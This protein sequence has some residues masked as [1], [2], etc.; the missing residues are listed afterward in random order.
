MRVTAYSMLIFGVLC[1]R[2]VAAAPFPRMDVNPGD[3]RVQATFSNAHA[4]TADT[5]S[6][7]GENVH[8]SIHIRGDP[9]TND[10]A[11]AEDKINANLLSSQTTSGGSSGTTTNDELCEDKKTTECTSSGNGRIPGWKVVAKAM[12]GLSISGDACFYSP[13]FMLPVVL[14]NHARFHKMMLSEFGLLFQVIAYHPANR[15]PGTDFART[16]GTSGEESKN[17]ARES[18]CLLDPSLWGIVGSG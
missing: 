6:G 2:F 18:R 17:F 10:N 4:A 12:E 16:S 3:R 9:P 5:Y 7:R 15:P 14:L 8:P 11:D 1:L 13:P